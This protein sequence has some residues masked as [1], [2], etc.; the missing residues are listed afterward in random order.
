MA[1][2]G[3]DGGELARLSPAGHSLRVNAEERG[4][5]GWGQ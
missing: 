1:T 3:A 2:E 4:D 5:L